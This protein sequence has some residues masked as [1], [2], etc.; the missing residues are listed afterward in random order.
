M[1][2]LLHLAEIQ[3]FPNRFNPTEPNRQSIRV[4]VQ[5]HRPETR[6]I[7]EEPTTSTNNDGESKKKKIP[8]LVVVSKL[9]KNEKRFQKKRKV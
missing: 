2:T 8:N 3:T 4:R 9:N 7:G 1:L 6:A 5:L